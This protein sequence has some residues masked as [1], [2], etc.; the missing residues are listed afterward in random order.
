MEPSPRLSER[1]RNI[2]ELKTK[3]LSHGCK[4]MGYMCESRSGSHSAFSN[5][6]GPESDGHRLNGCNSNQMHAK[7]PRI[8]CS[9]CL[10]AKFNSW[11]GYSWRHATR[12]CRCLHN[13]LHA[14]SPYGGGACSSCADSKSLSFGLNVHAGA[15]VSEQGIME[16][17]GQCACATRCEA[18]F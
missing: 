7:R 2:C 16:G 17:A 12:S 13:L 9:L 1:S 5:I 10:T 15:V 6:V 18:M 8:C 11:T 3:H 4:P 14:S